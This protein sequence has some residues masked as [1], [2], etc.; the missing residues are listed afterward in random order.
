M[1]DSIY[2]LLCA[3]A[4]SFL[5]QQ[6]MEQVLKSSTDEDYVDKVDDSVFVQF[7][8]IWL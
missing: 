2:F 4:S 1:S 5:Q 3:L 7:L 6:H 8:A